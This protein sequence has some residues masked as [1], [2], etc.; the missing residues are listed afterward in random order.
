MVLL[1]R[2]MAL[3]VGDP[4]GSTVDRIRRGSQAGL[5]TAGEAEDLVGAFEQIYQLRF[6]QEVAA[7]K[8][9]GT[10]DS[11]VAPGT[12]DPL[13]RRYLHDSLHAV[14]QIQ[15][16]VRKAWASGRTGRLD[17]A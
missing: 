17:L 7:L 9:G 6:D 13:R 2:W 1:G 12:L 4:S 14:S 3:V 8:S 10:T 15:T 5:L 16:A 11:Y